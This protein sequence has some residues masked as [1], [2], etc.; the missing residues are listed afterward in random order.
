MSAGADVGSDWIGPSPG[1]APSRRRSVSSGVGTVTLPWLSGISLG[2]E[3]HVSCPPAGVLH[4]VAGL[5][6]SPPSGWWGGSGGGVSRQSRG[7]GF[8]SDS[9][10]V[11]CWACWLY[12]GYWGGPWGGVWSLEACPLHPLAI[13]IASSSSSAGFGRV[14]LQGNSTYA[15]LFVLRTRV[16]SAGQLLIRRVL[17]CVVCD[18]C[19]YLLASSQ[20]FSF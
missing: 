11:G 13:V 4:S 15:E 6:P 18:S 5:A 10:W 3:G 9:C 7:A 16:H 20:R 19:A 17:P 2:R 1:P 12:Q 8:G 14:D